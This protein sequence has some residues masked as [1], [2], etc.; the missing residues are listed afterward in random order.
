M[1]VQ[2]LELNGNYKIKIHEKDGLRVADIYHRKTD[3]KKVGTFSFFNLSDT[4]CIKI[5]YKKGTHNKDHI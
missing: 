5:T 4:K 1:P 2:E 3:K